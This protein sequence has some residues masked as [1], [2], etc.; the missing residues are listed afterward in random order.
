MFIKYNGTNVHAFGHV[1]KAAMEGKKFI[2]APQDVKWFQPG[3][4]EFPKVVWDQN[5][6]HPQIKSMLKRG[7]IELFSYPAEIKVK[8]KKTGKIKRQKVVLGQDDRPIKLKWIDE[9][10]AIIIV[11]SMFVR[12]TLQRWLDEE[13]RHK[14]KKALRKQ[15]EPLLN[16]SDDEDGD[17]NDSDDFEDEDYE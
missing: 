16:N 1:T 6:D 4:N 8:D 14:V 3:W 10:M 2:Q 5:K 12:D 17:D 13:M 7:L 9:K 11:K 15:I